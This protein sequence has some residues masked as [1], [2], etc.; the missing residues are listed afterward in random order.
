MDGI[1]DLPNDRVGVLE[2]ELTAAV[3]E[4][5]RALLEDVAV[6]HGRYGIDVARV[7]PISVI[8]RLPNARSEYFQVV[9]DIE[10]VLK[11]RC[12]TITVGSLLALLWHFATIDGF[13]NGLFMTEADGTDLSLAMR[14]VV[15]GAIPAVEPYPGAYRSAK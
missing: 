2:I 1:V 14:E 11:I 3:L 8:M 4:S 12:R 9:A 6:L 13:P 15:C 10:E 7:D 5:P